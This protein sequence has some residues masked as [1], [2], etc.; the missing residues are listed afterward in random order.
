MAD[1]YIGLPQNLVS[2]ALWMRK[3]RMYFVSTSG[4][5][6]PMTLSSEMRMGCE[7]DP[8]CTFCGVL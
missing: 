3:C 2:N 5:I 1:R 6:G 7:P 4:I 8:T